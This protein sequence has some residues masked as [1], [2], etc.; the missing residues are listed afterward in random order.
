LHSKVLA[1]VRVFGV[2]HF[3]KLCAYVKANE[4]SF[5]LLTT[6]NGKERQYNEDRFLL[7][8]GGD[9]QNFLFKFV[10]FFVS[11]GLKILRFFRLKVL[12]EAEIIKV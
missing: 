11:L 5:S 3:N 2:A 7:H 12:F 1:F 8:L 4:Q 6:N 9:S 10:R